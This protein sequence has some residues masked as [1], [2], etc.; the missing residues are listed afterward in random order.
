MRQ[1]MR[2]RIASTMSPIRDEVRARVRAG[3]QIDR[4][5]RLERP[6]HA[7]AA[8]MLR[9][10]QRANRTRDALFETAVG[11]CTGFCV[12]AGVAPNWRG[13]CIRSPDHAT[14]AGRA[15]I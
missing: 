11:K 12:I 6:A 10:A 9:R 5:N 2:K 7:S 13:I 4:V 8:T 1:Q 14:H 15:A 3:P